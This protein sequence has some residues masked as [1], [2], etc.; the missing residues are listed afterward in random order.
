MYLEDY[1]AMYDINNAETFQK[2]IY[3]VHHMQNIT[4][5]NKKLFTGQLNAAYMW[6]INTH[7]TQSI[8]HFAINSL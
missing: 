8:Q 5:P 6:Y 2:L 3:M 7:G 4:T 1:M